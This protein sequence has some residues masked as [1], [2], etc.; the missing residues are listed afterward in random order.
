MISIFFISGISQQCAGKGAFRCIYRFLLH[1][2][3]LVLSL[4]TGV[5]LGF[6]VTFDPNFAFWASLSAEV[7]WAFSLTAA[8]SLWLKRLAAALTK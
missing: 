5:L 4:K 1:L 3:S 8:E 6:T 7:W 2:I